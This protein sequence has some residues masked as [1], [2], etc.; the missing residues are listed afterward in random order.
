MEPFDLDA[1]RPAQPFVVKIGEEERTLEFTP[2]S[3]L[4]ASEIMVQAKPATE[5]GKVSLSGKEMDQI[6]AIITREADKPKE[7]QF[8]M[9]LD[10]NRRL[11]L[12]HKL[13]AWYNETLGAEGKKK[14]CS[15]VSLGSTD[16]IPE[17][18]GD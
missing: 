1:V 7:D 5:E 12:T 3:L 16:S 4:R 14:E 18:S 2:D 9:S 8:F 15:A 13:I 10:A 17:K 6:L 11:K